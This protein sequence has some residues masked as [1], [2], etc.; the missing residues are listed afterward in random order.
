MR[1]TRYWMRHKSDTAYLT[2]N[3]SM[4]TFMARGISDSRAKICVVGATRG[5]E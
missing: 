2:N 4:K 1:E 3:K 5:S